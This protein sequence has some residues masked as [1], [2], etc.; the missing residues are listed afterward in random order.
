MVLLNEGMVVSSKG[1]R[2]LKSYM[3]HLTE[4]TYSCYPSRKFILRACEY[5]GKVFTVY[6]KVL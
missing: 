5:S 2:I 1:Y 3:Y 6:I 4:V